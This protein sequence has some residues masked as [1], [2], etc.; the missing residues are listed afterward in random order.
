MSQLENGA[1]S[2]PA[3][4]VEDLTKRYGEVEA[5]RGIDF[6]VQAGETFGFLGPNG[7]G[8]SRRLPPRR[9][10]HPRAGLRLRTVEEAE[11]G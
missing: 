10:W 8:K 9:A 4:S 1:A 6:A 2:A 11:R 7:A 5:V 3:V